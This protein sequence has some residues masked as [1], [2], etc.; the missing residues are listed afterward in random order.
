MSVPRSPS[1]GGASL[2]SMLIFYMLKADTGSLYPALHRLE[3]QK[4]IRSKWTVSA[5]NQ[6]VKAYRLT[7]AGKKPWPLTFQLGYPLRS[8]PFSI[9]QT[10][11]EANEK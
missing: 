5:N 8:H 2:S 6:R 3:R 4:W 7:A 11:R 10:S 9:R 1:G